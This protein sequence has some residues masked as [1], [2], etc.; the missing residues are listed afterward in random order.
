M[1]VQFPARPSGFNPLTG[2]CLSA[3]QNEASNSIS[4]PAIL[5]LNRLIRT[6]RPE[7]VLTRVGMET[8]SLGDDFSTLDG[9]NQ[10]QLNYRRCL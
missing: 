7:G 1:R 3:Q 9:Q 6:P 10:S 2:E 8:E 5:I 4:K